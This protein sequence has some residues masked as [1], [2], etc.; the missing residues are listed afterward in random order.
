LPARLRSRAPKGKQWL[1]QPAGKAKY[2]FV[3]SALPA[4]ITPN[5]MLTR[6]KVP[7]ATPGVIQLYALNDEQAL[8]AK[9]RYNRLVD[10]FTRVT[11]YSLQSHLRTT[12]PDLG[13]VETDELYVGV[14]R[15]GAQYVLPVQAKGSKDHVSVVQIQQDIELCRHRYPQ[16]I[17]R[18]IG[19]QTLKD[20]TIALFEFCVSAE[21]VRILL[22]RHYRLVPPNELTPQD[23]EEYRKAAETGD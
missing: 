19:A 11:C 5:A 8:L 12:V 2:R 21:G 3:A 16:L 9:V 23:L 14:D 1:I 17:C 6:I 18:P 10:L 15:G 4:Q 13:Q 22:E 7:D 20:G